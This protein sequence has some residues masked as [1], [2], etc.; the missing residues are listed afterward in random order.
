MVH[1]ET[2]GAAKQA[3]A[4]AEAVEAAATAAGAGVGSMSGDG[5]VAP[6]AGGLGRSAE[7]KQFAGGWLVDL[8]HAAV[9]RS[10]QGLCS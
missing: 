6:I 10:V 1:F 4:A 2:E 8:L 5:V 7:P 3:L 9:H